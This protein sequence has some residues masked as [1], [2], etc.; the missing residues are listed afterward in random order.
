MIVVVGGTPRR[1]P[2]AT[3]H[4][5][6]HV[7]TRAMPGRVVLTLLRLGPF[8]GALNT[9]RVEMTPAE[10]RALMCDGYAAASEAEALA[11]A[12]DG[13]RWDNRRERA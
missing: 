9:L 4:E 2:H 12:A 10:M 5:A 11:D 7:T 13:E 3:E 8:G 1:R 6:T